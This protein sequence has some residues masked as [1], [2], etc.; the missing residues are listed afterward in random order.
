[1]LKYERHLLVATVIA[2]LVI[3]ASILAIIFEIPL[4]FVGKA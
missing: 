1:M 4:P 2:L 3:A